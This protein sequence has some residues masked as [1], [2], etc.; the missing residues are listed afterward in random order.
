MLNVL[1]RTGLGT[2]LVSSRLF[3]SDGNFTPI[4]LRITF[5]GGTNIRLQGSTDPQW[6]WIDANGQKVGEKLLITGGCVLN[7]VC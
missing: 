4:F 3:H 1:F 6:G 7:K 5:T 2:T